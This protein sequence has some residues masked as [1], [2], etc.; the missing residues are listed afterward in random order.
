MSVLLY[1][2]NLPIHL[3]ASAIETLFARRSRQ[4]LQVDLLSNSD[5]GRSRGIAFVE[6]GNPADACAAIRELHGSELGGRLLAVGR[7]HRENN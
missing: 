6:M 1:V 4:V 5:T 2:G 7:A 3:V